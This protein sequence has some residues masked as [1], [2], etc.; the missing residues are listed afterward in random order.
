MWNEQVPFE[1][2]ANEMVKQL[3]A[4]DQKSVRSNSDPEVGDSHLGEVL[5]NEALPYFKD[6]AKPEENLTPLKINIRK[7][8]RTS[9]CFA[10]KMPLIS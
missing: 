2:L 1:A 3:K 8:M 6:F 4:G 5:S 9:S 10:S 7:G